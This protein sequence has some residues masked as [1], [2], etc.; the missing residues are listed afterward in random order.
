ML[1]SLKI[2]QAGGLPPGPVWPAG[3]AGGRSEMTAGLVRDP[4]ASNVP[5]PVGPALFV[6]VVIR[7]LTKILNPVIV[8]FAGR[9]HFPIAAQIHHVGRR[10]GKAYVTPATAHVHGDVIVIALTFGNQSDWA[11]NVRAAEGCTM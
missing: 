6:Q 3:R 8:K 9:R 10:S 2:R 5:Q 11:R 1:T 7:P 4:G